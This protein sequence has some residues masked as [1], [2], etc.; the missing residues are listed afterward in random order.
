MYK[1]FYKNG[2]LIETFEDKRTAMAEAF[3]NPF[4]V[5]LIGP[6]GR[7]DIPEHF[8]EAKELGLIDFQ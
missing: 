7:V 2:A 6:E 8:E 4:D 3:W 5:D 1:L